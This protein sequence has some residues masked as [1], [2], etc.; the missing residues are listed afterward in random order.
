MHEGHEILIRRLESIGSLSGKDRNALLAL[1][2]DV[3]LLDNDQDAVVEGE[4]PTSCCLLIDGFMHRYHILPDGKRQIMAI[5]TAGEIPDL[6]SLHL[7]RMDHTLAALNPSKVGFI[8]HDN[9]RHSIRERPNLGDLFWRETLIDSAIFRQWIVS[10]GRR[11]ARERLAHLLCELFVRQRAVGRAA[12]TACELPLTQTEIA[13][14]LGLSLVHVNRTLKQLRA[15]GLI[16]QEGRR[17]MIL[18]WERL[19]EVA[20]FDPTYLQLVRPIDF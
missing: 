3:Q 6:Q 16:A 2:M 7:Q 8:S 18:Q 12:A 17:L 14:V 1:S 10:L 9:L 19:K 5:H 13:D 15:D 20:D 11:S 4:R